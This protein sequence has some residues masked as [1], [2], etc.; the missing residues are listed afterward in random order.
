MSLAVFVILVIAEIALISLTFTKF[1]E[2]PAW[3]KNRTL[4]TLIE[5][6]VILAVMVLPIT[7]MKWRFILALG[8]A[9]VRLIFEALRLL[10]TRKKAEGK[11]KSKAGAVVSGVLSVIFVSLALV[12]AFVFTNYNGLDNSGSLTVDTASAILIDESRL[13]TFENDGTFREVPV[14]FYYPEEEGNYPLVVFSHGAFGYYQSNFST[15]TELAS[16]GYVVAALDHPHHAFFTKD[17]SGNMVIVDNQ[18]INDAMT[19][20]NGTDVSEEEIFTITKEWMELRTADENFVIDTI[21]STVGSGTLGKEWFTEQE[22]GILDVINKTDIEKIGLMGHSMGGATS[23]ALGRER[24]DIDAVVVIDGTMLT[25][26]EAAKDG[27][28]Q[29]IEEP[30]PTAI[31]DFTKEQDYNERKQIENDNGYFYVNDHVIENAKDGKLVVFSGANHMDFTDLPLISPTLSKMLS[32]ESNVDNE[33][34]MYTVNGIILNWFDY[35][36]KGEGALNI[37]ARY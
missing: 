15:Y 37:S 5:A 23:T 30:Y 18:F 31:L 16:N 33:E 20:G 4:T 9:A 13:D 3:L 34:F 12:P 2:K 19:I 21:K 1:A 17:T 14:H 32:G 25:E 36:L 24:D 10:I 7:H 6:V 22:S 29:Y 27:K 11:Y 26:R 8:L 28:Y 35:Y